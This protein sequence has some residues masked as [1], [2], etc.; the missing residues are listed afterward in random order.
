MNDLQQI[1]D[2][3]LFIADGCLVP[4]DGGSP[5]IYDAMASA[6]RALIALDRM[7]ETPAPQGDVCKTCGGDGIERCDNPDHG[8]LDALSFRGANE[9]ACPCCGHDEQYRMKHWDKTEKKF[10]WNKCPDCAAPTPAPTD[11]PLPTIKRQR[12]THSKVVS[13]FL[14]E[15]SSDEE[16]TLYGLHEQYADKS[17]RF[18]CEFDYFDIELGKIARDALIADLNP[19]PT[20]N[21]FCG[22][23]IIEDKSLD[24][25]E[26]RIYGQDKLKAR[27]KLQSGETEKVDLDA[28]KLDIE[29]Q[30]PSM[31]YTESSLVDV[32]IDHLSN[33]GRLR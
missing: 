26:I 31:N 2:E 3:L 19:A 5:D 12:D 32:V 4:P 22:I 11:N 29:K 7:I 20:E 1:R 14:K 33:T 28:I 25:N 23:K 21:S 9:S 30:F 8:L 10:V 18:V 16:Q 15:L 27:L 6:K 17:Y 24:E 13:Y